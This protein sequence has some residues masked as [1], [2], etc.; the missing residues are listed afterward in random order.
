MRQIIDVD[1]KTKKAEFARCKTDM[2]VVGRFSDGEPDDILRKLDEKLGGAVERLR[3]LGDFTG[4]ART[5]AVIYSNGKIAA[6]RLLLVGLGERGK[7]TL[8]T[9]RKAAAIAANRAVEMKARQ[10][11]LALHRAFAGNLDA[12]AMGRAIVEGVY[13]GSYRYDEYVSE[14]E[15]GRLGALEAQIVDPRP[16]QL[17]GLNAGIAPGVVIGRMQSYAPPWRTARPT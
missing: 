4:K 1:V 5:H 3:E 9:L 16:A 6:E 15:N 2:L 8:D 10:I 11:S 17:K 14:S 12:A 13:Y 7:A